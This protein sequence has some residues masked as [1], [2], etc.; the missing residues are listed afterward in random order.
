ML[1]NKYFLTIIINFL[2]VLS[3]TREYNDLANSITSINL[4]KTVIKIDRLEN[5]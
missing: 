5:I 4:I 1:E 3:P 2:T